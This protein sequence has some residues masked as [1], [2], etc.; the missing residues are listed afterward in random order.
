MPGAADHVWAELPADPEPWAWERRRALLRS[1]L[2]PADPEP[3]AWERRRALLR[4]EL[5]PDTPWLDLGC[6]AGRF[7][8]L[9]PGGIGVDVA[10]GAVERARAHGEARLM[11][12]NTIPLGYGEVGFVWC[13]E[14]LGFAA[15]ALGLLQ[16]CRR[17]LAPGGRIVVTTPG[18]RPLMRP[19]HPVDARLRFFTRATLAESLRASGFGDARVE[20][21]RWL[22]GRGSR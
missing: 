12:P 17:V 9:A 5:P 19:P 22:V 3:W 1:E 16:E 8:T 14:V 15:D 13:S 7:L 6:G 20:G 11:D 18:E 21:R 10:P 4:S 2:P